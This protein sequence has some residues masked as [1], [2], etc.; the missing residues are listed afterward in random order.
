M[1]KEQLILT[2]EDF[3]FLTECY[4]SDHISP[5]NKEKLSHDL[6]NVKIMRSEYLPSNVVRTNSSVLVTC[7]DKSQTFN[8][9][10]VSL[11]S[12]TKKS[13]QIPIS[14][15][16]AV[17]LLGYRTGS[18]VEWEMLDGI[19]QFQIVSVHQADVDSVLNSIIA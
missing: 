13:N 15:P 6:R 3:I 14:D 12:M 19:H 7:I 16:L 11:D 1:K 9:H 5:F 17:A 10:I 18:I 4:F 8:I 2:R